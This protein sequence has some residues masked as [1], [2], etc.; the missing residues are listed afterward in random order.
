MGRYIVEGQLGPG[1]VTETYLA[2]LAEDP[3]KK[4][5]A[6]EAGQLFALKLLRPDR[7]A[8][9][10]FPEAARRFVAAGQQLRGFHR[11]G[12]GRV[13][14]VSDDP[15]ATF[16]VTEHAAGHDL[17]RLMELSQAEGRGRAGVDPVLAGLLGSEIARL[18]HVGHAARP[19][20]PHLGLAP[21]NAMVTEE[22]EVVLLDA[23]IAAV[24]RAITEQPLERWSFVAPELAG[25]DTGTI[26]LSERAGVAADLYSLGALLYYLVAGQPPASAAPPELAGVAPSLSAAMRRLLAREP[27]D[28]PESAAV[29]VPWLSGG[30]ESVRE[31]QSLIA[32]GLRAAHE[33]ERKAVAMPASPPARRTPAPPSSNV[34]IILVLPSIKAPTTPVPPS[35]SKSPDVAVIVAEGAPGSQVPGPGARSGLWHVMLFVVL[36]VAGGLVAFVVQGWTHGPGNDLPGAASLA[37]PGGQPSVG[38]LP[39]AAKSSAGHAAD[40]GR[41][42]PRAAESSLR[43]AVLARVTGHLIAETVPPGA[44]VW[45]DGDLK[46]KTFADILV[47]GGRHRIVL[48]LPGHRM[49]RDVVDTGQ[50]VIIRRTLVPIAPPTRGDGFIR[51]ECET[52]GKFPILLD[53]QETGLLCPTRQLP[54][55]AG[56]HMVGIFVPGQG[57]AISVEVTVEAGPRSAF[58]RFSE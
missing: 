28:R 1:G 55:S 44:T 25:V 21:R 43:E 35:S 57:R 34:P 42:E 39:V 20:F 5:G 56:K 36:V 15:S 40:E 38:M 13:V 19:S 33:E 41:A 26:A 22:G 9:G 29:V 3:G 51:V 53:E 45:V 16:I 10:A 30:G 2:R 32:T 52:M 27:E 12:F 58:A 54:T 49:F 18:L 48:F 50:G 4:S 6:G 46:G 14:D 31:R 11:P 23:G 37:T 24:L 8:E 17:A 7:V 47:G